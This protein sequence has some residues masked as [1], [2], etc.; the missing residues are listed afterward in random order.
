MEFIA[1]PS[2]GIQK[3]LSRDSIEVFPLLADENGLVHG[4]P[5]TEE[6]R[7]QEVIQYANWPGDTQKES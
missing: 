7:G 3:A 5:L 2:V 1:R 6:L 4:I